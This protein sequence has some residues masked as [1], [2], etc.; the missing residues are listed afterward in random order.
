MIIT[1]TLDCAI[2]LNVNGEGI[3]ESNGVGN[4]DE[5][6]VGETSG[7]DRLGNVSSVVSGGSVD[8]GGILS[9][10]GTTTMGGPATIGVDNN[11]A[12][13]KS[14]VC[15]GTTDIE[16]AGGVD[17]NFS[18][19]Q[20]VLGND[21]LDDL[22]GEDLLDG[23][24]VNIGVMLC[25]DQD[26]VDTDG[27]D[28]TVGLLFVLNDNLRLAVGAQPGDLAGVTLG[29]Q[30]FADSIGKVV[31]V[32]VESLSIPLVGGISKHESLVA[33]AEVFIALSSVNGGGNVSVLGVDDL[34]DVALV[35][36]EALLLG[37]VADVLADLAGNLL[38]VD[39]I[40]G[41]VSLTK[42]EHL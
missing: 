27:S 4:L 7:N 41:H 23:L 24:V 18:V 10:E 25:G 35:A 26:V 37:V 14:S 5:D 19:D 15:F 38:E 3:S 21:L 20:H 11:F 34:D 6:A 40:L 29:G 28:T 36:V 42:Q 31:G 8:L 22:L 33:S 9:G 32:G 39:L 13:G 17:N 16:L 1:S 30:L 12:S 2:G